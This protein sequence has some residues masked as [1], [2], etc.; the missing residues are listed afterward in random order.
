MF[1]GS[2]VVGV[3]ANARV[4]SITQALPVAFTPLRRSSVVFVTFRTSAEAEARVR[5]V[6]DAFDPRLTLRVTP[7]SA[8][9]MDQLDNS[10][11]GASVAGG[12]G[13]LTLLLA[14]VGVFGV[15]AFIVEERRREIGIRLALGARRVDV[16]RTI[17]R[18]ARWP[19]LGG[20]GC[21]LALAVIAGFLLRSFLL[22]V[23]PIDPASYAIVGALL[24][25][26]GMAATWLPM[27]R[28]VRVD[29]AITLR[30]D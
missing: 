17:V 10:I 9:V 8:E 29:P 16:R 13:L 18:A 12:V 26:A 20:L 6:L 5:Q 28:A 24:L 15:C 30:C 11:I 2:V 22:G 23:S 27:R 14:M 25:A 1:D 7:A 19:L 4:T 3:A 21:G